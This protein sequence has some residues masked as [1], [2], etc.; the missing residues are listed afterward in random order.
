MKGKFESSKE[1]NQFTEPLK[2]IGSLVGENGVNIVF[3]KDENGKRVSMI[4]AINRNDGIII[5]HTW[6]SLFDSFEFQKDEQKI[7]ILKPQDLLSRLS[8]FDKDIPLEFEFDDCSLLSFLQKNCTLEFKTSD[9]ELIQEGKR[10]FK[11]V[12]WLATLDYSTSLD[13]F[14][15]ALNKMSEE[16]I[17]IT[18]QEEK[19][20]LK[21]SIKNKDTKSNTFTVYTDATVKENFD[22]IFRKKAFPIIF[23]T[24]DMKDIK[25]NIGSKLINISITTSYCKT[26]YFMSK[27]IA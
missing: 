4:P 18:G 23:G 27:M 19:G 24:K 21:L 16:C 14:I 12:D 6:N 2:T 5:I 10:S 25:I 17:F 13:K 8:I 26:E 11:G 20:R 9:T 7:G 3:F 1:L 15:T 22:I